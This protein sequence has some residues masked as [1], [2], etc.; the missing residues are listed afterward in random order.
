[1]SRQ[2]LRKNRKKKRR[3]HHPL[4]AA[5]ASKPALNGGQPPTNGT[6]PPAA[7]KFA[8]PPLER[9]EGTQHLNPDQALELAHEK[10]KSGD[11][12]TAA[13]LYQKILETQPQRADLRELL[14]QTLPLVEYQKKFL[15]LRRSPYL[16]YPSHMH[17][18]TIALCNAKCTFCVYPQLERIGT[19]MEDSLFRKIIEDLTEIPRNL[20]YAV[21]P[22]KI[23][24]P[25]L[26]KDIFNKLRIINEKLPN[27]SIILT[28]NGIS[29][30]KEHIDELN[31]IE[32][33][34]FFWISLNAHDRESYKRRMGVNAFDKVVENIHLVLEHFKY[35]DLVRI[36]R[37]LDNSAE[38]ILFY[39]YVERE[40]G[41]QKRLSGNGQGNWLGHVDT[42]YPVI[43][44]IPCMHWF[45]ISITCTGRVSFCCMD[46]HCEYPIGDVRE[47][48]VLEIYNNSELRNLREKSITREP[49]SPCDTCNFL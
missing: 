48:S 26:D 25:F 29:L 2:K 19:K 21:V 35:K 41:Q 14:I 11:I 4:D 28:T 33:F 10:R 45:E 31:E 34:D 15:E 18:E 27:A 39:E 42:V 6:A 38:D 47:K 3:Q 17:I 13:A 36:G 1:M 7:A 20:N 16:D 44:Y 8:P 24:D 9:R 46:G 40:F 30:R 22:Y 23:N 43:P 12:Q 5:P 49:V 37:V 32:N